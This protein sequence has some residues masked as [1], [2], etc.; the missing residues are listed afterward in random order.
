MLLILGAVTYGAYEAYSRMTSSF[1]PAEDQGVLLTII[2]LD[3][4]ATSQ[5]TRAVL[6]EVNAFMLEEE[7]EAVESTFASL[8]FGF[9]GSGQNQ[10]MVFV[11]LR[12][13]E[14]RADNPE[15]AAAAVAMRA[16][17]RFAGNRAGRI[18][19]M[20]PPAI[21]GLGNT[22]GFS[23]YL[24]DQGNNGTEALMAAANQLEVMSQ[25]ND[26]VTNLRVTGTESESALRI[27]VDQ[28]KAESFGLS[29]SSINSMLSVVFS[30]SEV[31]D[32][33]LGDSLR[34]VIVQ[35]DA[36]FRMQPEDIYD[37]YARNTNGEMVP[38]SAFVTTEW[39]PVSPTLRRFDVNRPGFTGGQNS[40]RIARYGTDIKE[41]DLEAV[42]T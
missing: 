5:Q 39:E 4:G 40:R 14:E 32:F 10:A 34:P 30:G 2:T 11:K 36:E 16:N 28:Q 3:E 1:I 37:W 9:G 12:D 19:V 26:A 31:N 25:Q 13:F 33:V 41:E 17:I 38:F 24:T 35:A 21:M 27:T 29:L 23:M 7:E 42:F 20:Q 15:S 22:G 8:G 6:E 18:F